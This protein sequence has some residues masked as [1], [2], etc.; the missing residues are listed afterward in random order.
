MHRLINLLFYKKLTKTHQEGPWGA[1]G[2]LKTLLIFSSDQLCGHEDRVI[3]PPSVLFGCY[4]KSDDF[5]V[6]LADK[7]LIDL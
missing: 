1:L 5:K 3:H 2:H 6:E 4:A 7:S